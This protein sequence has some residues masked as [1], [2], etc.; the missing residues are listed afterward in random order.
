FLLKIEQTVGRETWDEFV[1]TYFDTFAFQSMTR[2]KFLAYLKEHLLKGH[3]DWKK[4]IAIDKWVYSPGIPE[5]YP[6][7]KNP[8]FK[9]V[10]A[11]LDAYRNGASAEELKIDNWST[12]EWLRFLRKLPKNLT[13][14]QM[15]ALDEAFD[16]THTGN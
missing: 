10:D 15:T 4:A 11:Q 3:L 9:H 12:Y 13:Q 8:R 5:D 1:N 7:I 14:S 16:F 6:T 2:E